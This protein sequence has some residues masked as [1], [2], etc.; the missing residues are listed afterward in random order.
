VA[1]TG[2][3]ALLFSL[4]CDLVALP[5]LDLVKSPRRVS[6]VLN[7]IAPIGES[8]VA[9]YPNGHSGAF[10]LY[11]GRVHMPVLEDAREIDPFLAGPGRRVVLMTEDI[12]RRDREAIGQPYT[13]TPAGFVGHS[14]IVLLEKTGPDSVPACP[15]AGAIPPRR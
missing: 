4:G 13:L 9:L 15:P 8:A 7:R 12:Y 1:A 11:T 5:A 10:H 3:A 6:E 14:R 2:A